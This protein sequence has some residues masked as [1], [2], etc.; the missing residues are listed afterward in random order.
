VQLLPV[1][2]AELSLGEP[3]LLDWILLDAPLQNLRPGDGSW[4]LRVTINGD[5]FL[6]DQ[7]VPLWLKGWHS[8]DNGLL[9]E[10]V[11]G[12]GEPLNPPF[13]SLVSAVTLSTPGSGA[14]VAPRWLQGRLSDQELA[15]LLGE[16]PPP[17]PERDVD[18]DAEPEPEPEPE[19]QAETVVVAPP[20][21]ASEPEA[22]PQPE[23]DQQAS[24]NQ[25]QDQVQAQ[26]Q[27]TEPPLESALNQG[28]DQIQPEPEPA[29]QPAPPLPVPTQVPTAERVTSSTPLEGSAR[30]LVNPDG[31]LIQPQ[32]NGP[33][34]GLRQRFT[35]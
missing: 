25:S 13:N 18:A 6:I 21:P 3:V 1:S 33:L 34:A 27:T 30:E 19:P 28:E 11:D 4:R 32:S 20:E 17:A 9:L 29:M 15:Q 7:N 22:D 23:P 35:P 2:P 8:G 26:P 24:Q 5:S 14:A 10:L 31:S 16:L 12:R